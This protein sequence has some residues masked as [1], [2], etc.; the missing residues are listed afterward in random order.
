MKLDH[1][2]SYYRGGAI[3]SCPTGP[4]PNYSL[5]VRDTWVRFFGAL[6]DGARILDIGCGNGPLV[7]IARETA[8]E[9]SRSFE[10]DAVDLADIDPVANVPD[11]R[12][13]FDGVR[14]HAR[15]GTEDLPFDTASFDAVCGQ[16]IVEYTDVPETLREAARVL[17]PGGRCQ[18][19]LHHVDSIVVRNARESL[20][21]ADM[22]LNELR[23]LRRFRRYCDML[24]KSPQKAGPAEKAFFD[25]GARMR[26]AAEASTNPLFLEFVI[27]AIKS[28]LKNR[29]RVSQ[30]E[31]LKETNRLE[32]ELKN[33]VRRLEDLV[34]G[35]QTKDDMKRMM[36]QARDAGFRSIE[37]KAQLQDTD[38][39]VGWRLNMKRAD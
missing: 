29:S 27:N 5:E 30:G 35:A 6:P 31:H 7:L 21:Q 3:V 4:D 18:L 20:R 37:L 17:R 13:L 9:L 12:N 22:T 38:T 25:A 33:W 2:E 34:S 36:S 28:L 16:Y 24:A 26:E 32:R 10:I 11:G 14:F 15:V 1:W 8:A 19:I 23:L 39:L